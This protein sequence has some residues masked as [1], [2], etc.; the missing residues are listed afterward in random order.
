M[1]KGKS[2]ISPQKPPEKLSPKGKKALVEY[3]KKVGL[4]KEQVPLVSSN[5]S[6]EQSL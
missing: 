1:L 4:I 2:K 5:T 6:A 3:A